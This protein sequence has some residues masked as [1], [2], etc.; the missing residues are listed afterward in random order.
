MN[1][2]A[3]KYSKSATATIEAIGNQQADAD[4]RANN[5]SGAFGL[6]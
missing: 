1:F 3:S 6:I 4:I 2:S 5:V